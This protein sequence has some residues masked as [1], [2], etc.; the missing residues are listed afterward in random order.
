MIR[1]VG[2]KIRGQGNKD[3]HEYTNIEFYHVGLVS[4][5]LGFDF[6]Q[7]PGFDFDSAPSALIYIVSRR[8]RGFTQ[9]VFLFRNKPYRNDGQ[10]P[11]TSLLF[12]QGFL[13]N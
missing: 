7:P 5:R 4:W 12:Q 11:I 8:S 10:L 9:I 3:S 1:N 6:A 13:F 2:G